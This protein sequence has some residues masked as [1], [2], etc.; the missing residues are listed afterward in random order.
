MMII[1]VLVMLAFLVFAGMPLLV[2]RILLFSEKHYCVKGGI[3]AAVR[4]LA[5]VAAK[6]AMKDLLKDSIRIEGWLRANSFVESTAEA[7][8]LAIRTSIEH[9]LPTLISG[10]VARPAASMISA[11]LERELDLYISGVMH[12]RLIEL[13]DDLP[14]KLADRISQ[15][16]SEEMKDF[17]KEN[18]A[19]LFKKICAY[20]ILYAL[21]A[22]T[23]VGFLL[24][25]VIKLGGLDIG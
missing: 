17:Y 10:I 20:I 19:A 12:I 1:V 22:G 25:S 14:E 11:M 16:D 23:F 2:F 5:A 7:V 21:L 8:G 3:A 18:C 13:S 9:R 4:N 6:R 24:W 15:I